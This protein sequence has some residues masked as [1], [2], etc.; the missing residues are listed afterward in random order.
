SPLAQVIATEQ[1]ERD[2]D[3]Q[4]CV[5]LDRWQIEHAD[6][7]CVPSE[8]VLSSYKTLMGV[9]PETL[10]NLRLTSLGIVPDVTP[11]PTRQAG[12]HR[13]LF[14]GRCER[15]KGAHTLLDVLPDLLTAYPDWECH[16]VGNDKVR[17]VEGGTLKERFLAQ[18]RRAPWLA[19][20]VFHGAVDEAV[21]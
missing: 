20:V 13:L 10:V 9:T 18:H 11:M 16:L 17:L 6:T 19:R 15:R 7:V 4:A 21:L 2:E 8:G 3:L 1:W 14:V 12:P 5:A